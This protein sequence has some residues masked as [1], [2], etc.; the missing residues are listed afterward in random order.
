MS[1]FLCL[2]DMLEYCD[3]GNRNYIFM[4]DYTFINITLPFGIASNVFFARH[5]I[6]HN[7]NL[8]LYFAYSWYIFVFYFL[9]FL[10]VCDFDLDLSFVSHLDGAFLSVGPP[11]GLRFSETRSRFISGPSPDFLCHSVIFILLAFPPFSSLTLKRCFVLLCWSSVLL[12]FFPSDH[13]SL[14]PTPHSTSCNFSYL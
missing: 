10:C 1:V 14:F 2:L 5:F 11:H 8:L 7:A 9:S 4:V 6:L 13:K 12:V 3:L